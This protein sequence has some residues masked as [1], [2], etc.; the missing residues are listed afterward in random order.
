MRT[1][2]FPDSRLSPAEDPTERWIYDITLVAKSFEGEIARTTNFD[3]LAQLRQRLALAVLI[4]TD[5]E[6]LA[7][8]RGDAL[9]EELK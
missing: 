3:R 8:K 1:L 5:V 2:T 4:L 7:S 6:D 9:C